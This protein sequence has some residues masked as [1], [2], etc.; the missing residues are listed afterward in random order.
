MEYGVINVHFNRGNGR[1]A[2]VYG[3]GITRDLTTMI[4][5]CYP[6]DLSFLQLR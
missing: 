2:P 6:A 5:Q 3:L 1:Y 4:G